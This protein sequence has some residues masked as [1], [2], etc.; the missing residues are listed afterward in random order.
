MELLLLTTDPTSTTVLPAVHLLPVKVRS[1]APEPASL[2]TAGPYDLLLLDARHDLAAARTLCRRLAADGLAVPI[3][4]IVTEGGMAA[5][6]SGS[7]AMSSCPRP[8]RPRCTGCGCWRAA[9]RQSELGHD[10]RR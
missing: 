4:A 2:V 9:H 7:S 8:V 1:A 6:G 10:Q 5:I 3:L